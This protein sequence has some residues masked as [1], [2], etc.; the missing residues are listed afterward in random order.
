MF[1]YCTTIFILLQENKNLLQGGNF[2]EIQKENCSGN[3]S[4]NCCPYEYSGIEAISSAIR[5]CF[6]AANFHTVK[7]NTYYD[8]HHNRNKEHTNRSSTYRNCYPAARLRWT[9]SDEH[10]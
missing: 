10:P 1:L 7:S 4:T 8:S 2:Y 3:H 9:C 6:G 5:A